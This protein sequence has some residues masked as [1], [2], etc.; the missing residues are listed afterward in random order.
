MIAIAAEPEHP[1][2]RDQ[3]EL[4]RFR[5]H[6]FDGSLQYILGEL[7]EHPGL[8]SDIV[9]RIRG[10]GKMTDPL[11]Q[12]VPNEKFE[13]VFEEIQQTARRTQ[14]EIR[15]IRGRLPEGHPLRERLAIA[16]GELD[17]IARMDLAVNQNREPVDLNA[18]ISHVFQ[19]RGEVVSY[20]DKHG[21]PVTA[22]FRLARN[23][24]VLANADEIES[25]VRN[26]ASDATIHPE[27]VGPLRLRVS[28]RINPKTHQVSLTVASLGAEPLTRQLMR[29][30]GVKTFSTKAPDGTVDVHGQGKRWAR[31]VATAFDGSFRAFNQRLGRQRHPALELRLFKA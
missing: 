9:G 25:V 7:P 26:L 4:L 17:G 24:T 1:I 19:P 11:M 20:T 2:R 3:V 22:E 13:P 15:A 30:I 27:H 16:F 8:D 10:L 23:A 18:V 5:R 29:D 14:Q 12:P 21:R 28:T 6:N 31:R